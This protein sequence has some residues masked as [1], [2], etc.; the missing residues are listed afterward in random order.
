M[1]RL[2]GL[3]S[4]IGLGLLLGFVVGLMWPHKGPSIYAAPAAR[5]D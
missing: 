5:R 4:L 3:V 2:I 1:R